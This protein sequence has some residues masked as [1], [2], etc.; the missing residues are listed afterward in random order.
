M[1]VRVW[2]HRSLAA[3]WLVFGILSFFMGW[4]ESVALVWLA[5][6]YA[7]TVGHWS[8]AEAAD[9]HTLM[10]RLDSIERKL[11]SIRID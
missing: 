3:L 5:S 9:D 8:A 10:D 2:F 6:V 11:D 1:R 4:Q 7:N